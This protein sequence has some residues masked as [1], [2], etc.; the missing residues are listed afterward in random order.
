MYCCL[1]RSESGRLK[2]RG[3]VLRPSQYPVES[4]SSAAE[5]STTFT[6]TISSCPAP[7]TTPTVN[8]KESPGR[9]NP[10]SSPVSAKTTPN[11]AAYPYQPERIVLSSAISF[12]G[13]VSVRMKSRRVWIMREAGPGAVLRSPVLRD[14]AVDDVLVLLD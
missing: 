3:P 13:V 6:Q 8:R 4:P 5:L 9:K 14:Q 11:I 10:M 7:A 1:K 2:M 12:S